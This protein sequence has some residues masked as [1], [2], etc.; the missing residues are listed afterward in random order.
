MPQNHLDQQQQCWTKPHQRDRYGKTSRISPC[1][2]II[3]A[4]Q[5]QA[6]QELETL[7]QRKDKAQS[8]LVDKMFAIMAER[9]AMIASIEKELLVAFTRI[10][11]LRELKANMVAEELQSW[12][13]E[14]DADL[15]ESNLPGLRKLVS[16]RLLS[17][18]NG[19]QSAP[20]KFTGDPG[21][22]P[23]FIFWRLFWLCLQ[24]D[25]LRKDSIMWSRKYLRRLLKT[26]TISH[27]A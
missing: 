16:L 21:R 23:A 1:L 8:D 13:S 17:Q 11:R 3:Q 15:G 2:S 22:G 26:R 18:Q 12:E 27:I 20:A 4:L 25:V 24:R 9:D 7:Q 14:R 10:Q 5:E 6:R 19:A